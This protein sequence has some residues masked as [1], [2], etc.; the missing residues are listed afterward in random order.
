LT[1]ESHPDCRAAHGGPVARWTSKSLY[2]NALQVALARSGFAQFMPN[3]RGSTGR[4]QGYA[5][6]ILHEM[7]VRD[8]IDILSGID[9]LVDRGIADGERLAVT[10]ISHGGF[11]SCWMV[12]QDDRFKAAAAV[13]PITDWTSQRLT[14]DIP[15][16]NANFVGEPTTGL[17]SA[18]LH[19][20]RVSSQ[21]LI[22]AGA[23]DRCTPPGQAEEFHHALRL[24]GKPS[25]LLVY[26]QEGHGIRSN[27]AAVIDHLARIVD[28]FQRHVLI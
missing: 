22:I 17:P 16:F 3:P 21:M 23:R 20:D 4:G 11:M 24:A 15:T 13:S 7:G 14:S 27:P 1:L 10:G 6:A 5:Q 26:P 12:T 25:T 18:I 2:D 9:A 8:V 19:A 28:F